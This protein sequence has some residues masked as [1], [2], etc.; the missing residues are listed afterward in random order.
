MFFRD[1]LHF[2]DAV[3]WLTFTCSK[4]TKETADKGQ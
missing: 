2:A 1:F 4:S 3:A